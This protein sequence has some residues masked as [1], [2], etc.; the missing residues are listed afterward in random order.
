MIINQFLLYH[1]VNI[2]KVKHKI[3]GIICIICKYVYLV[4]NSYNNIVERL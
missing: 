2:N 3:Y 4:N 1:N